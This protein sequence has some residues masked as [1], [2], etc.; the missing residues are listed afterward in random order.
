M[1]TP[2]SLNGVTVQIPVKGD[3]PFTSD[4]HDA[5]AK[6]VT[7]LETLRT[8]TLS[9]TPASGNA[10]LSNKILD[11][12]SLS[13]SSVLVENSDTIVPSQKAVKAYAD[14]IDTKTMDGAASSTTDNIVTFGDTTGKV[15]KD[16]LLT[17]SAL[18][19]LIDPLGIPKTWMGSTAP[20]NHILASQ[21]SI[22]DATSGATFTGTA[23]QALF[24]AL[25]NTAPATGGNGYGHWLKTSAGTD[26][27]KDAINAT[28]DWNA[29]KRMYFDYRGA[30]LRAIGAGVGWTET[31]ETNTLNAKQDDA[32]QGHWHAQRFTG[33]SGDSYATAA[34]SGGNNDTAP[35]GPVRSP[36]SDGTNGTPRYNS[37][38]TR[39]K[40]IGINIIFRYQ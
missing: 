14:A 38:E 30:V 8:N 20:T 21:V 37:K 23:Y 13:T 32:L 19:D 28:N 2:L 39:M 29:H 15:A 3:T 1:S 6:T 11:K 24:T 25:W 5:C 7:T 22:G 34:G 40:N 12:A 4:Q 16:G 18:K 10:S 36:I 27:T 35:S 26:T 33:G 31:T 9:G 17:I